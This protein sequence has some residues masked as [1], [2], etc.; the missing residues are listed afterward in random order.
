M[1][2]NFF[3][4]CIC[5]L[6]LELLIEQIKI[7]RKIFEKVALVGVIAVAQNRLSPE[8]QLVVFQLIFYIDKLSI[9]FVLL[10]FFGRTHSLVAT[11]IAHCFHF[12]GN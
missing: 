9:E 3:V 2:R 11:R 8:L 7:E 10:G 1:S 4:D 5:C 12:K 6:Y